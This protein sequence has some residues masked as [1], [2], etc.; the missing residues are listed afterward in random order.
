M[1]R[2]SFDLTNAQEREL[3]I[4]KSEEFLDKK[5]CISCD[6]NDVVATVGNHCKAILFQTDDMM[7][8]A[9]AIEHVEKELF[10]QGYDSIGNVS[11][12]LHV[13]AGA[14]HE[15]VIVQFALLTEWG[16]KLNPNTT[17]II[18]GCSVNGKHEHIILSVLMAY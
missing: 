15:L 13:Y 1:F 9:E 4:E 8:L 16:N 12:L 17:D 11:I 14:K 3:C 10:G 6:F 2:K 7:T 18:W 5:G